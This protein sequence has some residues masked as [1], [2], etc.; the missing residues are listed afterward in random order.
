MNEECQHGK[1]LVCSGYAI[2]SNPV[3][4]VITFGEEVYEFKLKKDRNFIKSH[5]N[6]E[7]P[8][9]PKKIF[10]GNSGNISKWCEKDRNFFN[11]IVS[12]REKYTFRYTGC[13]VFDIHRILCQGGI[14]IY[15]SDSKNKK[16]KLRMF[17]ECMPM[18]FIV[19]AAKGMAYDGN[20]R[21]LD[22]HILVPHQKTPIYIGCKRDV[23]IYKHF[24]QMNKKNF[25]IETYRGSGS[26]DLSVDEG[27]TIKDYTILN[28]NTWTRMTSVDGKSGIVP[29]KCLFLEKQRY[30]N[31]EI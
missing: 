24:Y 17:Y 6:I 26:E 4:F 3:I 25:V 13:M 16:G 21:L 22:N 30:K 5:K 15:P 1:N 19:E 11:W 9:K 7:I 27:D 12:E 18:A 8:S 31:I 28:D 14:F 23:T 29:T 2:Y 20:K 10:S